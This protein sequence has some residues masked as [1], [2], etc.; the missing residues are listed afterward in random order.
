MIDIVFS[1][2]TTGSMYPC[3]TS[4]RQRVSETVKKL[5]KELSDLRIGIISHGDYCDG[6]GWLS[7]LDLT[8][9]QDKIIKFIQNAKSTG[10]GDAP[11]AYEYVLYHA[12]T[13]AWRGK[14]KKAFVLIGDDVPHSPYESQN[15]LKLDWRK[16]LE[17]IQLK[18]ISVYG[19]Q[20]LDRNH[21]T[22]FYQEI[23]KSTGGFHLKLNQ[24]SQVTDMILAVCYKQQGNEQLEK[25]E[26]Q[27]LS[28][29]KI[30]RNM[31]AIFTKLLNRDP[32]TGR[33]V[34]RKTADAST[35]SSRF[36]IM[37]VDSDSRISD[38][39][40][41]MGIDFEPGRGFYEFTK[42]ETIQGHKEVIVKE[43]DT[44]D[45]YYGNDARKLIGL[46]TNGSN[47]N[48]SPHYADKYT[49]FVQ[50]TSYTRKLIGGTKFLYEVKDY[51]R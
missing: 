3:L 30:D 14:A 37:D 45:I 17:K 25:F 44:G 7:Q 9:D 47:G 12:Q 13:L 10:G 11:E 51:D 43:N 23:A 48:F 39:V 21:A 28:E 2:D 20:A 22:Y 24:F 5:F 6:A 31:D 4:L 26:S 40:R 38:F 8:D 50:S 15:T 42:R 36:Q 32:K 35:F 49:T 41:G 46:P 16:E 34:S 33:F 1:F 29:K 27:L 19:V 18:D